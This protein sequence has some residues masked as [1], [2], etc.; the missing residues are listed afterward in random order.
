MMERNN[1]NNS[2]SSDRVVVAPSNPDNS[3]ISNVPIE[4]VSAASSVGSRLGD[5][6]SPNVYVEPSTGELTSV[7]PSSVVGTQSGG[8]QLTTITVAVPGPLSPNDPVLLQAAAAAAG[9]TVSL[10]THPLPPTVSVSLPTMPA[11]QES[12][13]KWKYEQNKDNK[14]SSSL[15]SCV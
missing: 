1:N 3:V 4:L 8:L 9:T 10:P 14:T 5:P 13:L 15:V 7:I 6:G 11:L 2:S 12:T